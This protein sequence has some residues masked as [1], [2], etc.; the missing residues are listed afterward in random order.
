MYFVTQIQFATIF[1]IKW[2]ALKI[3]FLKVMVQFKDTKFYDKKF[4]K[5]YRNQRKPGPETKN[6]CF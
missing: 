2:L 4:Y 3:L 5:K 1:S 6:I